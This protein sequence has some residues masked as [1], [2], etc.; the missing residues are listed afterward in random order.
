MS[1]F[2]SA[3]MPKA[4]GGSAVV[5]DFGFERCYS[6]SSSANTPAAAPTDV[7]VLQGSASKLIRV[8]KIMVSGLATTA[9][10]LVCNLIRRSAANTGGTSTTPAGVSLHPGNGTATGVVWL[11]TANPSAL[12]S[13]VGT[14]LSFRVNMGVATAIGPQV[15]FDFRGT[16][17]IVLR[18]T[19]DYLAF[20]FGGGTVPA[21][22]VL[23]FNIIWSEE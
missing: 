21:G 11:Y 20:N 23:D 4:A 3:G 14:L 9:G 10:Q 5:T 16:Q 17:G 7:L 6:Y 19:S 12:G 8:R 1:T 2:R 22:G 13:A 15:Q 18:G